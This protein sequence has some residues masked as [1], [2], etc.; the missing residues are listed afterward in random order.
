MNAY[1]IHIADRE[2]ETAALLSKTS[3]IAAY[4]QSPADRKTPV[5]AQHIFER[6][7]ITADLEAIEALL[8]ERSRS[9]VTALTDAGA[10]NIRA[11]GKRLRAAYVLLASHLGTY[12]FSQARHAAVAVELIHNASLVHDDLVD[13]TEQRRGHSTIHTRWD[14][15]VA[16]ML[17]DYFFALSAAEMARCHDRRIIQ[18]IAQ[19]VQTV[20]TGELHPVLDVTPFDTAM[21]QYLYKTGAKTAA[22]FEV[23]C[24]SG[25]VTGGGSSN[26]IAALERYGHDM[27]MAFQI[28]DDML[29]FMGNEQTLGKPAGN[30]LRQGTIT[31]PLIYAANSSDGA[32]LRDIAGASELS[33]TQV[34]HAIRDVVRLGGISKARADAERYANRAITHLE[35]FA[36]SPARQALT[37]LA[38]F[39]VERQL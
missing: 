23:A 14:N 7:R 39:V 15:G 30:D 18:F 21:S 28:V 35:R 32:F 12:D 17:G 11:G 4:K 29:D 16:L 24:K 13:R 2:A 38:R 22:L 26:D 31:L 6:A 25:M 33:D 20:V 36:P 19:A 37:D 5:S 8:L 34:A 3:Q 1:D 10:Y 9:R 27:G